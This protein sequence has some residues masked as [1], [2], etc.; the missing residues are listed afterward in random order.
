MLERVRAAVAE[1][2]AR[3]GDRRV[4]Y[5]QVDVAP[6]EG[7]QFVLTGAVLDAATYAAIADGLLD[8]FP[9]LCFD[10]GGVQVLRSP[11]PQML[12]VAT[13]LAG[14]HAGPAFDAEL[15]SQ[16]VNGRPLEVLMARDDWVFVRQADGYLGWA[17][18]PYLVDTAAVEPTHL[19]AAPVCLLN[20]SPDG[21]SPL[22]TRVMGGTPVAVSRI[23]DEWARVTLAGDLAGYAHGADLRALAALPFGEAGR[24]RQIVADAGRYVGVPYLWGGCT[25]L[26]IDCS[27]FAQLLY[28]LSGVTLPRDADTQFQAGQPVTYPYQPGDLLFFGEGGEPA[29]HITHVGVSLG[30]WRTVHSSRANN[31]VYEED[32]QLAN[33]LRSSFAG[34]RTFLAED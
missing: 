31:G 19:I 33:R 22:V 11:T 28:C 32:V 7:N 2:G 30:G 12:A 15:V 18:W 23:E 21:D 29:G 27:G 25:A 26:G 20:D 8:R 10:A 14:L 4:C 24:R 13:N 16:L 34:A 17:Y 9:D 6:G 3:C 1:I 5:F